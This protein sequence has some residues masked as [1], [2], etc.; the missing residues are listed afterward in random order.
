[1]SEENVGYGLV[2]SFPDQSPSFVHGFE[3][4]GIWEQMKF[5]RLGAS[6][7]LSMTVHTENLEVIER[8]AI[9]QG[10][11][12]SATLTAVQGWHRI[13]MQFDKEPKREN[14]HGLKVIK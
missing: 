11:T 2:V 10:W 8:M 3:A 6:A 7:A 5:A 1:M 12:F 13:E 14:P 9:S 4:G